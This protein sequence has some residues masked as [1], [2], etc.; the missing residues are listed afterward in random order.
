MPFLKYFKCK[1]LF[2]WGVKGGV[3]NNQINY[4]SKG[5]KRKTILVKGWLSV[6]LISFA[7]K[8]ILPFQTTKYSQK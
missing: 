7:T 8:L 6:L 5:N 2:S 3:K 4:T 1:L